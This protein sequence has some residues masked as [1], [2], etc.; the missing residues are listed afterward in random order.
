[1]N[2]KSLFF[3]CV[4]CATCIYAY[5]KQKTRGNNQIKLEN[6]HFTPKATPKTLNKPRKKQ[7]ELSMTSLS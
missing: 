4:F 7:A 5:Y 6:Q 1:M 2:F 3:P